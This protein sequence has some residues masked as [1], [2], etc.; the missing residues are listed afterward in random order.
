MPD[1]DRLHIWCLPWVGLSRE[2]SFASVRICPANKFLSDYIIDQNQR[3]QLKQYLAGFVDRN[4]R[5]TNDEAAFCFIDGKNLARLPDEEIGLIR[6]SVNALAF[7]GIIEGTLKALEEGNSSY[8]VPSTSDKFHLMYHE[9]LNGDVYWRTGKISN[10]GMLKLF[11]VHKPAHLI[12]IVPSRINEVFD[13]LSR[14]SEGKALNNR[15]RVLIGLES[16]N[17]AHTNAEE[18]SD[19]TRM[20]LMCMS[21]ETLFSKGDQ[22]ER[23]AQKIDEMCPW[24]PITE[25]EEVKDRAA[26]TARLVKLSSAGKWF[27]NFYDLRSEI[28]HGQGQATEKDL[29]FNGPDMWTETQAVAAMIVWQLVN[30]RLSLAR[31]L[32]NEGERALMKEGAANKNGKKRMDERARKIHEK[33]GWSAGS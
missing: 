33:L 27:W 1:L 22:K 17:L 15:R 12:D 11:R 19:S 18:V 20:L 16:F 9:I 32:G 7:A 3:A 25:T 10:Y 6:E 13:A 26:G 4:G 5:T 31:C 23:M 28:A 14:F 30:T 2:Y 24:L 21:M 29:I 8:V